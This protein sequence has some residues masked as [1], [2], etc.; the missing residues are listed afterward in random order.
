MVK[1][2]TFVFNPFQVN[3]YLLYE[4]S[5]NCAIIDPACYTREEEMA[6][7]AFISENN[8]KPSF[9]LLTHGH[10]DH[11]LGCQFI[12]SKYGLKPITHAGS[13]P[14]L[15]NAVSYG[16]TFGFSVNQP[17]MPEKLLDHGEKLNLGGRAIE[18]LH[19]PGHA[20]GSICFYLEEQKV[21]FAGDVLF[22]MGIGRTDLPTGDYD[23]LIEAIKTNLLSLPEDVIVYPGHGPSTTI[24]EEK[25][26]NPFLNGF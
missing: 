9:L 1:I 15:E 24:K 23:T 22:R 6:L 10:I 16:S 8:L 21:L 7:E 14:F 25:D 4:D 19:T 20:E 17:P 26:M 12:F 18:A 11:I 3:T 13:L 5:G 2:K